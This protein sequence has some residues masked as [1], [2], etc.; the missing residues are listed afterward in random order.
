MP[1]LLLSSVFVSQPPILACVAHDHPRL[2]D[3]A[4]TKGGICMPNMYSSR[5]GNYA[6]I[7]DSS[8]MN[9]KTISKLCA[10]DG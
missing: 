2:L 8:M 1:Q 10:D 4:A 3:V 6:Y 7:Y 5:R 9:L